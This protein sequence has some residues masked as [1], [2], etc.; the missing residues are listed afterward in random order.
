MVVVISGAGGCGDNAGGCGDGA[1]VEV[2]VRMIMVR[3]LR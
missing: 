3:W 2:I 1:G